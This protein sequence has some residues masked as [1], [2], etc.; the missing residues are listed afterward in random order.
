MQNKIVRILFKQK[1]QET[2]L[3]YKKINIKTFLEIFYAACLNFGNK[4]KQLTPYHPTILHNIY[5]QY[6]SQSPR[7][8]TYILPIYNGILKSILI[9]Y[10][11]QVN[12]PLN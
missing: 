5:N 8:N 1:K 2:I 4:L 3:M 12:L 7:H 10:N 9:T 11:V 6:K